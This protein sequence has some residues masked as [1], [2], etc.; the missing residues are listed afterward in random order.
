MCN[1]SW[2][3]FLRHGKCHAEGI[4]HL[5][6]YIAA[7]FLAAL[8]HLHGSPPHHTHSIS[9]TL[10]VLFLDN[11]GQTSYCLRV[12]GD[13]VRVFVRVYVCASCTDDVTHS[14]YRAVF[15]N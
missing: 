4:E 10:H 14:C 11:Q 3:F 13:F 12:D 6:A 2:R 9:A 1:A 15:Q 7:L 5:R 8:Q